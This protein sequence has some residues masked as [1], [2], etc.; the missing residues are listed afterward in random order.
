MRGLLIGCVVAVAPLAAADPP[1]PRV[2]NNNY[3]FGKK[4]TS[5]VTQVALDRGPRWKAD[6]DD[7]PLPARKAIRAADALKVRV[8]KLADG[9]TWEFKGAALK[10]LGKDQWYW[11]VTYEAEKE[12]VASFGPWRLELIVLMDGTAVEPVVTTDKK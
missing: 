1:A 8:A 12:G 3:A 4:Y 11:S 6:A 2:T 9:W 5:T 7:P 10:P